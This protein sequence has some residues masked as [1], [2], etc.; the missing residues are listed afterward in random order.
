M[1]RAMDPGATWSFVLP[2]QEGM[3]D[4][5]RMECRFL[6][7]RGV[8]KFRDARAAVLSAGT[9]TDMVRLMREALE[10]AVV[11]V[12]GL[13][14]GLEGVDGLLEVATI[15]QVLE[16]LGEIVKRQT[17]AERDRKNS[18]SR[19]PGSPEPSAASAGPDGA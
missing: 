18:E 10:Q 13:P 5:V 15:P 4:P 19:Q 7:V 11:S 1:L 16:W 8:M 6:S 14:P 12:H 2:G 9:D 3:A 17:L